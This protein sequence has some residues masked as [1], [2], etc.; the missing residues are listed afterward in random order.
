M[1][2][3]EAVKDGKLDEAQ[4]LMENGATVNYADKN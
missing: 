1:R 2:L 3:F 4:R